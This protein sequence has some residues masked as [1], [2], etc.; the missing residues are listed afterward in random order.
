MTERKVAEGRLEKLADDLVP[1]VREAQ[2]GTD[3]GGESGG[4]NAP[5]PGDLDRAVREAQEDLD[6][7]V[8]EAQEDLDAGDDEE[9]AED[10]GR[11]WFDAP[12]DGVK[13][14]LVYLIDDARPPWVALA[15]LRLMWPGRRF[16]V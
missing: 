3:P 8:K 16:K 14:L 2:G 7:E 1:E 11:Y 13:I 10:L 12:G 6:R 5:P 9:V 4:V 15:L